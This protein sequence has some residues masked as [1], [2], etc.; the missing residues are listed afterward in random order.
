M[1]NWFKLAVLTLLLVITAVVLFKP[2]T[3]KQLRDWYFSKK[4]DYNK[5]DINLVAGEH[6]ETYYQNQLAELS[7]AS[8]TDS[9]TIDVQV[10]YFTNCDTTPIPV[11][12][13]EESIR[14]QNRLLH[15]NKA[16]INIH[17]LPTRV[18]L[19]SPLSNNE[20]I[21]AAYMNQV[22]LDKY[23]YNANYWSEKYYVP[24]AINCMIYN[25]DEGD[26]V[27]RAY[28]IPSTVFKMRL[29]AI[30]P[31]YVTFLHEF[32]HAL[33]LRHTHEFDN[34]GEIYSTTS[35][36]LVGDTPATCP[37]T[38]LVGPDCEL[39]KNWKAIRVARHNHEVLRSNPMN[40]LE[41]LNNYEKQAAMRNIMSYTYKPCRTHL[42]DEQ[43][44]RIFYT[45]L[46]TTELRET[47]REYRKGFLFKVNY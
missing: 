44:G 16:N 36:D 18:V 1:N 9:I 27:A 5:V 28:G 38:E 35:G 30:H 10:T 14:K 3:E 31:K 21:P 37:L 7:N 47:I 4:D 32:L 41:D 8:I 23:R 6:G 45:I 17:L 24:G 25:D 19:G 15:N 26:G 11:K 12:Y 39:V 46:T 13:I 40:N 29:D 22:A 34:T 33:G 43:I 42:T 20:E 2:S